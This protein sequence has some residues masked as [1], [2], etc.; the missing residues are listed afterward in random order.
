MAQ[1]PIYANTP[2]TSTNVRYT[3]KDHHADAPHEN[4]PDSAHS[5]NNSSDLQ[6]PVCPRSTWLVLVAC[7]LLLV[8]V[9]PVIVY[10]TRQ[11]Q[12]ALE[13]QLSAAER[14][15]H[16]LKARNV[17]DITDLQKQFEAIA[18]HCASGWKIF[19][20]KCYC[21]STDMKNWTESRD[22]CVTMG[23]H[24]VIIESAE[25]LYFLKKHGMGSNWI[26][27]TDS[28]K[29]GD[30]R[31]VDNT[32]LSDSSRF[33]YGKEP[34]NWKGDKVIHPEGEDCAQMDFTRPYY[35]NWL[36]AFCDSHKKMICESK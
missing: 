27:L 34:D 20:G 35:G 8:I 29:E 15:L 7:T 3:S 25:E 10:C 1:D 17:K 4:V 22:A 24:L 23:G 6:T 9:I 18:K 16:E 30:W 13:I 2:S 28:V 36:D 12:A 32:P 33:W 11:K 5:A 19:N 26:G 14:E 31:W 21:F